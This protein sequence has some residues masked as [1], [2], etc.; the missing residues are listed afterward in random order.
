M[1]ES[2]HPV[3]DCYCTGHSYYGLAIY[4]PSPAFIFIHKTCPPPAVCALP[5]QFAFQYST[6]VPLP[7]SKMDAAGTREGKEGEG[8]PV[9]ERYGL[10]RRLRVVTLRVRERWQERAA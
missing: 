9:E 4:I 1:G 8:G 2:R 7:P 5:S 10:Q 6:I 3:Q